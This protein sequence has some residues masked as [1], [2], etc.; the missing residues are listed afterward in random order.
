MND[1]VVEYQ[2]PRVEK[3]S[4]HVIPQIDLDSDGCLTMWTSIDNLG[5]TKALGR[6]LTISEM[7]GL[8]KA[9]KRIIRRYP[10]DYECGD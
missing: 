9:L 4:G 7:K 3:C 1:V 8:R 2:I 5:T 10:S 6:M